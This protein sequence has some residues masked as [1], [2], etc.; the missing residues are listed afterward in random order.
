MED[1]KALFVGIGCDIIDI[2]EKCS[3]MH[4]KDIDAL[5]TNV[6]Q[7]NKKNALLKK[8]YDLEENISKM[9][10]AITKATLSGVSN[11]VIVPETTTGGKSLNEEETATAEA[12]VADIDP[13]EDK[14]T[15][16]SKS[17][18]KEEVIE[19]AKSNK[20]KEEESKEPVVEVAKP[21]V[22]TSKSSRKKKEE[23]AETPKPSK[24]KEEVTESKEPA[25]ET[26]KQDK[27]ETAKPS[28]SITAVEVVT[29][30][31]DGEE[32]QPLHLK[33]KKI[34]KHIKTHVWNEYVGPDFTNARCLCC[35]KEKIDFRNF[36]CGHV[37]AESKG[38]DLTIKNLRPI[39]AGC[40]LGMG[41]MSMNEFTKTFF[42]WEV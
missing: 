27:K 39:C 41:T 26:P 3:K 17:K 40:N 6:I 18:K 42:G 22:E 7:L 33:R 15:K 37:I 35:K 5:F 30:D 1:I 21:V 34:P 12:P 4:T 38:G 8:I 13:T 16:K 14:A 10:V 9:R 29:E 32:K 20:K 31:S 19:V 24:K 11:T 36:H 2:N 28:K 23:V 25:G